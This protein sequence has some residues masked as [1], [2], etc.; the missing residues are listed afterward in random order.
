MPAPVIHNM[1]KLYSSHSQH[2][3]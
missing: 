2:Q 1:H 3:L